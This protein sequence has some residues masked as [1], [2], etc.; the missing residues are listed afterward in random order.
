MRG[1]LVVKPHRPTQ[2]RVLIGAVVVA[3]LV[4]GYLLFEYGR[5]QGG[6]DTL[7]TRAEQ[8]TLQ[9]RIRELS[10]EN[11]DLRQK[12]ALLET[13]RGVDREA[14]SQV[15]GT[16]A[17]LQRQL[18]EQREE[19]DFYRTIVTPADG[20]SGL[21]IQELSVSTGAQA[22]SFRLHLVLVQA[23]QHDQVISGVVNLSVDGAEA[24]KPVSYALGRLVSDA[25]PVPMGFSF[26][27]FQNLERE[28]MLPDGFVPQRVN[29]EVTPNGRQAKVIRQSFDWTTK[30]T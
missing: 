6:F 5:R 21:R 3:A 20:V 15:E 19:L 16:L 18:Q 13:S 7:E 9:T 29:V 24:G 22:S 2:A 28:L 27:Y 10:V 17:D 12:I 26:R 23:A 14:Y 4:A 11:E 8:E 25:E 30:T 1:Q